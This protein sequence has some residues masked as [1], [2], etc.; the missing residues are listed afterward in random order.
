LPSIPSNAAQA[1]T[2]RRLDGYD[3]QDVAIVPACEECGERWLP[4]DPERWRAEFL[5]DGPDDV[6]KFWCP[7]CWR[8]E[9]D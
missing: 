4:S 2:G 8:R 6:L 5:D 1:H 7:D 3:S 9:F